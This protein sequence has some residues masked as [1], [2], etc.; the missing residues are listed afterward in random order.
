[1]SEEKDDCY[2]EWAVSGRWIGKGTSWRTGALFQ[3]TK[4]GCSAS[5]YQDAIKKAG[6]MHSNFVE[7]DWRREQ[8]G[9]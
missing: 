9:G 4:C 2:H 5:S 1:M 6:R 3:C 7:Y 8:G